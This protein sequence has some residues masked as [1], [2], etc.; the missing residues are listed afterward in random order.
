MYDVTD[1]LD[2]VAMNVAFV[3]CHGVKNEFNRTID[4]RAETLYANQRYKLMICSTKP[5]I[6][7]KNNKA[8]TPM[9]R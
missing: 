2:V 6:H 1:F 4:I 5:H 9:I 7:A 8:T 3:P